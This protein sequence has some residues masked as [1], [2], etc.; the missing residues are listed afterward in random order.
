[1][2][3]RFLVIGLVFFLLY[4]ICY[5]DSWREQFK[6]NDQLVS[7][8]TLLSRIK[9]GHNISLVRCTIS[10]DFYY[11]NDTVEQCIGFYKSTFKNEFYFAYIQFNSPPS[12]SHCVFLDT[13]TFSSIYF[14]PSVHTFLTAVSFSGNIFKSLFTF[15]NNTCSAMVRFD[16]TIF[17][18][19]ANFRGTEFK[20]YVDFRGTRFNGGPYSGS[21]EGSKLINT[22]FINADLSNVIME[23]DTICESSMSSLAYAKGLR[24]LKFSTP[25]NLSRIKDYFR[26][27]NYR[28]PEREIT[29]ALKRHDQ[30]II[31]K[32]A[33]DYTTE[34]GSNFVR[35]IQ[36]L[37]GIWFVCSIIYY[38]LFRF[39]KDSG[40]LV[41]TV[42]FRQVGGQITSRNHTQKYSMNTLSSNIR[43]ACLFSLLSAFNIGFRNFNFSRIIRL[44]LKKE[45]DLRPTGIIRTISGV[46]A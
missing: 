45:M 46:Q 27:N 30:N 32:V 42:E 31:E 17:E 38:L 24:Q 12:F 28:Q 9:S 19:Y 23:P 5:G 3:K 10:G 21:F 41:T 35:P 18:Q 15:S 6:R 20:S 22:S 29:L 14:R 34:Y 4:T 40:L 43:Y 16:S 8:D 2:I 36:I 25:E 33:F 7:A 11:Y 1:M 13:V 26:L 44:L 37:L 39:R